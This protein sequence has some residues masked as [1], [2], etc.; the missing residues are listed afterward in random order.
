VT[1]GSPRPFLAGALI[2]RDEAA[3]L[4]GCLASLVGVVDEVHV[5]DTGSTDGTAELA[6]ELGAVVARTMWTDD[7]A[8]A[9]NAAQ[10]GWT[11]EWVLSIDADER[12]VVDRPALDALLAGTDADILHVEID[13]AHDEA[14]YTHRSARLYRPD[15]TVWTGRVHEE[16]VGRSGPAK[17]EIAPRSVIAVSHLGYADAARRTTK[18]LR[19]AELAQAALDALAT[20]GDRAEPQMVARALLDLGRSLVGAGRRQDAVD[21]FETLRELFPGMPEW[22]E[23]TDFLARAVLAAGLDAAC[24]VLVEQLRSAGARPSYCD[25]LAAQALA[26]LGEVDRAWHL[27]AGVDQVID[28]AG[29]RYDPAALRELTDLVGQLRAAELA[30]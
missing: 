22:L 26:Q 2:V 29:R 3:N 18:A 11:A 9:R 13:N 23:A 30:S 16:P 20:Q 4:P 27:L 8:A 14:P 17:V 12:L 25:W 7:F 5:L 24:L 19:N 1:T 28:T 6:A 15:T 10:S 21:V